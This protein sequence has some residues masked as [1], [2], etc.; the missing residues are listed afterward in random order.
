MKDKKNLEVLLKVIQRSYDTNPAMQKVI[1]ASMIEV[2]AE[3][4]ASPEHAFFILL[5]LCCCLYHA[6]YLRKKSKQECWRHKKQL[7][8]ILG[9]T[10]KGGNF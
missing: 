8:Y 6:G 5:F 10:Q 2:W 4:D 3:E 1:H 7:M 9:V